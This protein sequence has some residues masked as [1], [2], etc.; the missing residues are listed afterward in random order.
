MNWATTTCYIVVAR[1]SINNVEYKFIEL[2]FY[3]EIFLEKTV[4][5]NDFLNSKWVKY[6][7]DGHASL[8]N[9]MFSPLIIRNKAIG[10]IGLVNKPGGFTDTD[11][12][13]ALS[14]TKLA[15]IVLNNNNMFN[16]LEESEA[17]YRSL[18]ENS[19]E[20]IGLAKGNYCVFANKA[21][22]D[23]F[24]YK[25]FNEFK[26]IP[27]VDCVAP[28]YK[29]FIKN[30]IKKRQEGEY[31]PTKFEYKIIRKDGEIRDIEISSNEIFIKGEKDVINRISS[32]SIKCS[33]WK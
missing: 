33:C 24:G 17:K 18:I 27:L 14:F 21:L 23:I 10:L 29:E 32:I 5:D 2:N 11:V 4:Y 20:G 30:R 9:V 28:E 3:K 12:N 22:L 16:A 19:T 7:P 31:L 6:M 13:T 25:N 15:A 8:D 26:K 1:Y